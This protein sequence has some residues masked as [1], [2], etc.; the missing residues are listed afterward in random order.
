MHDRGLLDETLVVCLGEMGRTPRVGNRGQADGRDHWRSCFPCLIAG[1]GVP[2]GVTYGRSDKEA[3][4]PLDHPVS[5]EDLACTIF[6]ALGIDPHAPLLRDRQGR[7]V[8]LV[9]GG[10]TLEALFA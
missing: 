9:D 7:P 10:R 5:P 3:G 6:H 8:A 2:G 1:A 4:Q